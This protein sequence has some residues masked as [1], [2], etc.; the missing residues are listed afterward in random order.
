MREMDGD[1][2]SNGKCQ[3]TEVLYTIFLFFLLDFSNRT[4]SIEIH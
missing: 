3:G 2:Q 4:N 1:F